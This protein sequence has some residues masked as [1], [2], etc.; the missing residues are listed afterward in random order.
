M[1]DLGDE[2]DAGTAIASQDIVE[3]S[4]GHAGTLGDFCNAE[5]LVVHLNSKIA[6]EGLAKTRD[7]LNTDF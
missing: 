2:V 4:T 3:V 1:S 6:D 7:F 5:L